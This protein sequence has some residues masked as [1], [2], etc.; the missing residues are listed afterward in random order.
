[1][2]GFPHDAS[3]KVLLAHKELMADLGLGYLHEDLTGDI[4]WDSLKLVSPEYVTGDLRRY[5]NDLVWRLRRRGTDPEGEEW[6]YVFAILEFQSTPDPYM[7]VRM[8]NYMGAFY[9]DRIAHAPPAQD[10]KLP[11]LYPLVIYNGRRKWNG[12]CELDG[13]IQPSGPG[14][15][16]YR[17]ALRFKLLEVRSCG[18]ARTKRNLAEAM[19][20]IERSGT[21]DDA[22]QVMD[23]LLEKFAEG[24]YERVDRSF[25][26]WLTAFI[27]NRYPKRRIP[28]FTS[29]KEVRMQVH[30]DLIPWG[31]QQVERQAREAAARA[32]ARATAKGLAEGRVKGL[33]EGR[34]KARQEVLPMFRRS[35]ANRARDR[36]GERTARLLTSEIE[37]LEDLAAF[38]RI[39]GWL[40]TCESGESLLAL[41]RAG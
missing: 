5:S 30:D 37:L 28:T 15:E 22:V 13:V 36:F 9:Q 21:L 18:K 41:V 11:V 38:D 17:P 7:A 32:A 31:E 19:F 8:M 1:M 40:E 34:A 26:E 24:G 25:A 27:R 39:C 4:D 23:E 2:H 29:V 20:R 6:I 14:L 3:Y 16:Q 12:G 33:D 10:E 35:L